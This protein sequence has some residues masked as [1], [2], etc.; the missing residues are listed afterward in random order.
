VTLE[1][2]YVTVSSYVL[3]LLLHIG[4]AQA[5]YPSCHVSEKVVL[6]FGRLMN[7]SNHGT[8]VFFCDVLMQK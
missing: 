1:L 8:E 5:N 7:K 3:L 4:C 6:S 2:Y